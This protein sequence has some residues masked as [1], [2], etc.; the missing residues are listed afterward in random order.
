M[1]SLLL[2]NGP[3]GIGKSTI[4]ERYVAE[5]PGTLNLDIDRLRS[6]IGGWREDFEAAGEVVRPLALA[7]VTV[8]L[9][10]GRDVVMPQYLGRLAELDRFEAAAVECEASFLEIV[11]MDTLAR[12]LNRFNARGVDLHHPWH[13]EIRE[14][15]LRLG[16]DDYLTELYCQLTEALRRRP[17]AITVKTRDGC[18][19]ETYQQVIRV[20]ADQMT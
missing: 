3:P 15:V 7:M 12:S 19:E 13:D 14:I 5:H 11:L 8:H 2:V 10:S 20:V 4:A 17:D 9:R 18:I 16:G 6:F 1:P